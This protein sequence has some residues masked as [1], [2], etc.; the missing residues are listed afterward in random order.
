ML[1]QGYVVFDFYLE[2]LFYISMNIRHVPKKHY[3]E[4]VAV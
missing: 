2:K 4:T 1:Q 3:T